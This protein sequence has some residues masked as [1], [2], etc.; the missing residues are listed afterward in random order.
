MP[1]HP[2]R[3]PPL[4]ELAVDM[5]EASALA[6]AN[7]DSVV[8]PQQSGNVQTQEIESLSS[9]SFIHRI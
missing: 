5:E 4:L 7:R 2:R 1:D 3:S 8:L 6:Q 9:G